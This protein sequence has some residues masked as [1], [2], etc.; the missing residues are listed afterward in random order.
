MLWFQILISGFYR[1]C[2]VASVRKQQRTFIFCLLIY[3]G[4]NLTSLAIQHCILDLWQ[5]FP[6]GSNGKESACNARDLSSILGR[7][8]GEGKGNLLQYSCLENPHRQRSLAGYSPW[9]HKEVDMTERLTLSFS[10]GFPGGSEGK[11]SACNS[12]NPG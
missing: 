1:G 7:S 11:G 12:G 5:S 6:D 2:P 10:Q 8:S 4:F 3:P 9:D